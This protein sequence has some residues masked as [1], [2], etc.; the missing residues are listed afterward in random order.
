MALKSMGGQEDRSKK[1]KQERTKEMMTQG[2]LNRRQFELAKH[3][4]NRASAEEDPARTASLRPKG[5]APKEVAI[6]IPRSNFG[7][8]RIAMAKEKTAEATAKAKER[9]A[10]LKTSAGE[11]AAKA[12]AL[13]EE[14][15]AQAKAA[16]DKRMHSSS[17]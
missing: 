2:S 17:S 9:A 14:K 15:A 5:M 12:K 6:S 10:A 8:K 11:R 4:K 16:A 13:A 3:G 1:A 7:N